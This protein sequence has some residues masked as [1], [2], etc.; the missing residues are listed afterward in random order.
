MSVKRR[1][2][3]AGE[4]YTQM[5]TGSDEAYV[6]ASIYDRDTSALRAELTNECKR[7]E[8]MD[9]RRAVAVHRAEQAE[10][11]LAAAREAL[12]T[13][14]GVL[15]RYGCCDSDCPHYADH[16]HGCTCGFVA[17]LH[18]SPAGKEK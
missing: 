13:M 15:H 5:R 18:S 16:L 3:G 4:G 12:A 14:N 7:S 8:D 9:C 1:Y 11:E 17:A 10:A 2:F 6:L